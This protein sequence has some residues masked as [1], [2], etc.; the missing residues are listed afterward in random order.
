VGEYDL[1]SKSDEPPNL[2]ELRPYYNDL[3][4]EYFPAKIGFSIEPHGLVL[5]HEVG[6]FCGEYTLLAAILTDCCAEGD[7]E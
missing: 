4:A 5:E 3:I 7:Q 1:Y 2:N 6:L